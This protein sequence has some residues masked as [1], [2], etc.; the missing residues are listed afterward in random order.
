[1]IIKIYSVGWWKIIE[2]N[3]FKKASLFHPNVEVCSVTN[4]RAMVIDAIK[5]F[6]KKQ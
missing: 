3:R 6:R 5:S 2:A 1:M 4:A